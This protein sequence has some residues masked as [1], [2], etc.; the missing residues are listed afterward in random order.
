M[1]EVT[2]NPGRAVDIVLP[3]YAWADETPVAII[4]AETDGETTLLGIFDLESLTLDFAEARNVKLLGVDPP[5][6]VP[7]T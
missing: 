7:S 6:D 3:Q 5:S 1:T 4:Q 2:G